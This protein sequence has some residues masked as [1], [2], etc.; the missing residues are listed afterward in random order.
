[1]EP[2]TGLSSAVGGSCGGCPSPGRWLVS[3]LNIQPTS[4]LLS[5][6]LPLSYSWVFRKF[7]LNVTTYVPQGGGL[8]GAV[9][10]FMPLVWQCLCPGDR[11][12]LALVA[13]GSWS[14]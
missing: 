2:K 5:I 10:D 14:L 13:K 3:K 11:A 8:L 12:M 6:K 1:M 7:S 9:E 4:R